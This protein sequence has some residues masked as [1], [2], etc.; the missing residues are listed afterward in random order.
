MIQCWKN[1]VERLRGNKGQA[2]TEFMLVLPLMLILILAT[3]SLGLMIYTKT[4]LV[5]SAGNAARTA[6][7]LYYDT[8]Y[9]NE[10]KVQKIEKSAYDILN[11]GIDGR[12]RSVTVAADE[13]NGL[14]K[15]TVK[16][17]FKYIFP[18]LGDIFD[19]TEYQLEYSAISAIQ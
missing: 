19:K 18:M 1:G 11:N 4:L 3:L 15:V 12:E 14:I 6:S 17:K 5:L 8:N 16:Y 7:Y 2:M 13:M 9:T 10:E